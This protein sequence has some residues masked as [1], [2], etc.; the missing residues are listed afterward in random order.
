VQK[1]F[2]TFFPFFP[3]IWPIK[4]GN[5]K[6]GK[7]GKKSGKTGNGDDLATDLRKRLS[8]ENLNKILFVHENLPLIDYNLIIID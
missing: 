8:T 5:G 7:T 4:T 3:V 1:N 2:Y 6:A